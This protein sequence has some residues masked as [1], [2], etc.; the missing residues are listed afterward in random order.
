MTEGQ[1]PI[2][3]FA[4]ED[5]K[6]T[7]AAALH[8]LLSTGPRDGAQVARLVGERAEHWHRY[9]NGTRKPSDEKV[10]EW[11]ERT[12]T[13]VAARSGVWVAEHSGSAT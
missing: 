1:T 12:G 2:E 7:A 11:S 8:R 6:N 3:V 5:R 13:A 4:E 9:R 10:R